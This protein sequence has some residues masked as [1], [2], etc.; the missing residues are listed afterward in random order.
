MVLGPGQGQ[1][2][3]L[4]IAC[5][6]RNIGLAVYIANLGDNSEAILPTILV[7]MFVGFGLQ[8]P[9]SVWARKQLPAAS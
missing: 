7:Y 5:L 6:A 8:I 2:S 3:G 9:Y 1:R 4:A